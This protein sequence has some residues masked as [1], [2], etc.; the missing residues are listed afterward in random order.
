MSADAA[1][2]SGAR[3]RRAGLL[4]AVLI[5]LWIAVLH[6]LFLFHAGPLWRDEAGSVGFAAMSTVGGDMEQ[7]P[8]R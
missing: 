4:T 2:N 6:V 3:W 7:P 1:D 8:L 5:T